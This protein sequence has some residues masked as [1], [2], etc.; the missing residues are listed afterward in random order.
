MADPRSAEEILEEIETGADLAAPTTVGG[1]ETIHKGNMSSEMDT[2]TLD[3]EHSSDLNRRS[4]S[5]LLRHLDLNQFGLYN[6]YPLVFGSGST[7]YDHDTGPG[8]AIHGTIDGASWD[9][10]SSQIG[11]ASLSFDGSNDIVEINDNPE[12]DNRTLSAWVNLSG[13]GSGSP[14]ICGTPGEHFIQYAD[15]GS[16][17]LQFRYVI[18]DSGTQYDSG[19]NAAYST[20]TWHHVAGTYDGSTIKVLINGSLGNSTSHTGTVDQTSNVAGIGALRSS[21]TSVGPWNEEKEWDAYQGQSGV[22]HESLSTTDRTDNT[23]LEHGYTYGSITKSLISYY[24]LD[25]GSGS[26]ATDS[27]TGHDGSVNGATWISGHIGSNA[28]S[29]DN[30]D[31]DVVV[32]PFPTFHDEKGATFSFWVRQDADDDG[33]YIDLRDASNSD[34]GYGIFYDASATN[35]VGFVV[36]SGGSATRIAA[37]ITLDTW[38]HVVCTY[39]GSDMRLFINGTLQAG[40]TSPGS[41]WVSDNKLIIGNSDNFTGWYI[42]ADLDEIRIYDR[43]L[44]ESEINTLNNLTS[45]PDVTDKDTLY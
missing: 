38:E 22:A 15:D 21:G 4:T 23:L 42:G 31:D 37:N 18:Y 19:W 6:W 10:S 7:A 3:G 28:L 35:E 32:D 39:D 26:T 12:S 9:T 27:A 29:F 34:Q 43:A 16:G 11:G 45:P 5:T 20:G 1:N 2:D 30:T 33:Y 44:S 41:S 25:D 14:V 13:F 40:P 8:D 36:D 17:N 24:K